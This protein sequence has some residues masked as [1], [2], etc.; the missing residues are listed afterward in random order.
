MS[1]PLPFLFL[2][3]VGCNGVIT[4]GGKP[5]PADEPVVDGIAADSVGATPSTSQLWIGGQA[6]GLLSSSTR[7]LSYTLS[8]DAGQ[9]VSIRL[10]GVATDGSILDTV[11]YVYGPKDAN[12]H[13]KRVAVNDDRNLDDFGSALR[14]T[15]AAAGEYLV[16]ATSYFK[17]DPG[18]T[19]LTVGCPDGPCFPQLG[20]DDPMPAKHLQVAPFANPEVLAYFNLHFGEGADPAASWPNAHVDGLARLLASDA[21]EDGVTGA[22]AGSDGA[23]VSEILQAAASLS[24]AQRNRLQGALDAYIG[25]PTAFA[26][27]LSPLAQESLLIGQS[28]DPLP[29][30]APAA[31]DGVVEQLVQSWPG[32]VLQGTEVLA[33][34]KN[35]KLYGFAINVTLAKTDAAGSVTQMWEGLETFNGEGTYLGDFSLPAHEPYPGP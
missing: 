11:L 27:N 32:S 21:R 33:Q 2:F 28:W 7:Q 13:R 6:Y 26:H 35:G 3:V 9:Q 16:I 30:P 20:P 19:A 17:P 25:S 23:F 8:L 4:P 31:L 29:A 1:K 12:G 14:V 10:G 24:T 34:G 5:L 18:Q 22:V 15:A